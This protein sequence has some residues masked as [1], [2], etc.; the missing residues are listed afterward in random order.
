MNGDSNQ[1]HMAPHTA[2]LI[3]RV[4]NAKIHIHQRDRILAYL[5]VF[6]LCLYDGMTTHSHMEIRSLCFARSLHV[7]IDFILI[8]HKTTNLNG[9]K[10]CQKLGQCFGFE[11]SSTF[12]DNIAF[13]LFVLYLLFCN[14]PHFYLH[15]YRLN[16]Y[17]R[18]LCH[19]FLNRDD[20]YRFC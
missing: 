13:Y 9:F 18:M 1:H 2:T 4:P 11:H 10:W 3:C 20:S 5:P 15:I 8:P 16:F 7:C 14:R 12:L 6:L 17:V 19:Y